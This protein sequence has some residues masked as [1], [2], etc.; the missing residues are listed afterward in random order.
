M[1]LLLHSRLP[2]LVPGLIIDR[3]PVPAVRARR[4]SRR[5][6]YGSRKRVVRI[7]DGLRGGSGREGEA[8]I[9]VGGKVDARRRKRGREGVEGD[10]SR[11]PIL[12][13]WVVEGLPRVRVDPVP[14]AV[15]G[16]WWIEG[17]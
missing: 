4:R 11:L 6:N 3:R 13:L 8:A 14:D 15:P 5:V 16:L 1:R 2:N 17:G 9:V 7:R 10:E 12:L